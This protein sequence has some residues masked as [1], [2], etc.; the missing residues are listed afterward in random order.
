MDA[1]FLLDEI[2]REGARR[3][4]VA[5][6][7]TEGAAYLEAHGNERDD[8]G[9]LR[10]QPLVAAVPREELRACDEEDLPIGEPAGDR[11]VAVR[12]SEDRLDLDKIS[13]PFSRFPFC[14]FLPFLN[15]PLLPQLSDLRCTVADGAEHIFGI[16]S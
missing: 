16:V 11:R 1:R 3:M 9:H 6:L 4:L 5:A 2:A 7:E 10:Y 13:L 14:P 15:H 12:G 8:E